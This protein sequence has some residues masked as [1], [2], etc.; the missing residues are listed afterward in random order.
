MNVAELI[1]A[2]QEQPQDAPVLVAALGAD[3][4]GVPDTYTDPAGRVRLTYRDTVVI[5]GGDPQLP[6]G[7]GRTIKDT[8]L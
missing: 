4:D 1:A 3:R 8:R 2:L 7:S 5:D 6:F